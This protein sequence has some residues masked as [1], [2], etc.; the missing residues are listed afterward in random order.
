M[1]VMYLDESEQGDFLAVGGF[2]CRVGEVRE[3][4]SAWAQAKADMGLEPTQA[5]KWSPR[6]VEQERLKATIGVDEARRCVASVIAGLPLEIVGIVLQERRG[7]Y[8]VLGRCSRGVIEVDIAEWKDIYPRGGGARH[9]YPR[10]VEFALQRFADHL[11]LLAPE[12]R[13][14][15]HLV[16]DDLQWASNPGRMTKKL[17]AQLEKM[18][19]TDSWVIRDWI[20][21]GAQALREA[22]A[23]WYRT[24]F[25]KPYER[26]GN[27][28][29]LGLES[30]FHECHDRWSDAMQVADFIAGC[31]GA[32]VSDLARGEQ[33]VARD[34]V[35]A[36]RPRI[37]AT[38]SIGSGLWGNGFVLWP[39][40]PEIWAKAKGALE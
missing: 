14:H 13:E 37:R 24:G 29:A 19:E 1:P 22:Y 9:F 21:K 25:A 30:T 27:L 11:R 16:L 7:S 38:G 12:N 31:F 36:L 39:P 32:F 2:Y 34:C 6:G 15:S 23:R 18:P 26:L 20:E 8:A 10:G 35:R 33:G 4:E 28:E 40:N 17:T 5:M 3:V